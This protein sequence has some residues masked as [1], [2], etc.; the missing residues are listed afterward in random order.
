MIGIKL[1][2]IFS[3][4]FFVDILHICAQFE[5]M[6]HGGEE[7]FECWSRGCQNTKTTRRLKF[8][9]LILGNICMYVGQFWK[10]DLCVYYTFHT[11]KT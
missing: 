10:L 6:I 11:N 1:S 4:G 2:I 3:I 7:T 9:G 8:G 5:Y